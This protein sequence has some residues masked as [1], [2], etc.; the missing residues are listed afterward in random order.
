MKAKTALKVAE[1]LVTVAIIVIREVKEAKEKKE[2]P[3]YYNR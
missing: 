2:Q 1:I 3:S